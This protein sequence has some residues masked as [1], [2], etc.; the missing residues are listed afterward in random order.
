MKK[1]L[2]IILILISCS[3]NK[4]N[5]TLN[6]IDEE[7]KKI[8]N[9]TEITSFSKNGVEV[10]LKKLTLEKKE[11]K[12]LKKTVYT[13]NSLLIKKDIKK[14]ITFLSETPDITGPAGSD[15]DYV[16][17]KKDLIKEINSKEWLYKVLFKEINDLKKIQKD[18]F[19]ESSWYQVLIRRCIADKKNYMFT[20]GKYIGFKNLKN[21]YYFQI[22][23]V[24]KE[25]AYLKINI[26]KFEEN[27]KIKWKIV[28]VASN[29]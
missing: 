4:T 27:K 20:I 25:F 11:E 1:I 29:G 15:L 17:T 8:I 5:L 22:N 18:A 26:K 23:G 13:I 2:F 21:V 7:I 19:G 12:D 9:D 16:F 6:Q 10:V 14:F 3:N 24:E 28:G